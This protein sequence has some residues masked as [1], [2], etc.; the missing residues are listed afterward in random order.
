MRKQKR[1]VGACRRC[2]GI[3]EDSTRF[4]CAHCLMSWLVKH[5]LALAKITKRL[6]GGGH[7]TAV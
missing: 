6:D 1:I 3:K 4:R 7:D 5:T 2:G